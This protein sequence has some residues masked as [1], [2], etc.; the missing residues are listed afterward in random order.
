M[1]L[2]EGLHLITAPAPKPDYVCHLRA[3]AGVVFSVPE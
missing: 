1:K 3:T 2:T